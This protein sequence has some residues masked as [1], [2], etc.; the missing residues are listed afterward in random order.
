MA[1]KIRFP[2]KMKNGAEVRTL[3]ELRENFDLESVLG[4]F[5]DGKLLTW[6]ADRYYDD[7]AEAVSALTA[8]MPD[9]NAKL[10]EIL[11]VKY[12]PEDD[13]ADLEYIQRRNG[14][15]RIISA[16]TDDKDILNNIDLVALDQ[17]DLFDILDEKPEKVYLYG[18]KFSIPFGVKNVCY[19]GVNKPLVIIDKTKYANDFEEV[20]ISFSNIK[21]EKDAFKHRYP[22][23]IGEFD[24]ENGVLKEGKP[25]VNGTCVIPYGVTSINKYAFE[26]NSNIVSITMPNSLTSIGYHAFYQCTNLKNVIIPK[27]VNSIGE[28]SFADTVWLE[29]KKHENALVIVNNIVIDGSN[30]TEDIS[31]PDGVTCIAAGAFS[32]NAK[33]TSIRLPNTVTSIGNSAF[34]WCYNIE[35]I[36]IPNSV[37][38]IGES[39]FEYCSKLL[40]ITIPNGMTEI[41]NSTFGYCKSLA[42]VKI[43]DSITRIGS[44]VFYHCFTL[45]NIVIPNNVKKLNR[46]LLNVLHGLIP[47]NV[48]HRL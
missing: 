42:Y 48:K 38:R 12:Q 21:F 10:C 2:L 13:D 47:K 17:D 7:K 11:E 24:I 26:K 34:S 30:C 16:F 43:P 28:D 46:M 40:S 29:N 36:E 32:S 45:S 44:Y 37:S 31:I 8:D 35:S 3:D 39:A 25:Y 22:D 27:S 6:L 19:I 1:R 33:I 5:M 18:D 14:K 9:L 20:G 15:F 23:P 41:Q 4:Y